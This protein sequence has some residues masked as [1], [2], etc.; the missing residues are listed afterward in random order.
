MLFMVMFFTLSLI[1]GVI[2][3]FLYTL[4]SFNVFPNAFQRAGVV[5]KRKM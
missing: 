1:A 2:H 4:K 5:L 3:L